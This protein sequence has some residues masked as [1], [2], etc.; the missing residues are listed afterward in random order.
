MKS[1]ITRSR[2]AENAAIAEVD[3][4]DNIR[5]A[6]IGLALVSNN[7][8]LNEKML[9]KMTDELLNNPEIVL[10]DQRIESFNY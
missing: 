5:A 4:H 7:P 8:E 9:N 10:D 6:V 3:E 2:H 1:F